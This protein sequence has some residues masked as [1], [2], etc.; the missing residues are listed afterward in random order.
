MKVEQKFIVTIKDSP[1]ELS[2]QEAEALYYELQKELG[3]MPKA[4]T[5]SAW[6]R[7]TDS[8]TSDIPIWLKDYE[9]LKTTPATEPIP[10]P[11]WKVWCL[12]KL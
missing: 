1:F 12:E 3:L 7:N 2:K 6:P 10:N 4:N 5:P 9:Y 11:D 8:L